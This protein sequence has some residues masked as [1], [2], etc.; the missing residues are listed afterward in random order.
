MCTHW[1]LHCGYSSR[2]F[3]AIFFFSTSTVVALKSIS[4]RRITSKAM[5]KLYMSDALCKLSH[6]QQLADDLKHRNPTDIAQDSIQSEFVAYNPLVQR[7]FVHF[8]FLSSI[9]FE[10]FSMLNI[11]SIRLNSI[12]VT[13]NF[14]FSARLK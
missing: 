13:A 6:T 14:S 1:A 11:P 5:V 4:P 2:I 12:C 9:S 3:V 7:R 8:T 10:F